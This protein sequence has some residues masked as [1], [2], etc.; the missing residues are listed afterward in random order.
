[1]RTTSFVL[2]LAVAASLGATA[3]G[4]NGRRPAAR[5]ILSVVLE[6][7]RCGARLLAMLLVT[8]LGLPPV[9]AD[10]PIPGYLMIADRNN[11][12]VLIVSPTKRI[13]W[14]DG[15][16]RGPDDAFFT[17]GYQSIITNEEFNDTLTEVSLATR[18]RIWRYGHDTVP[19]SSPGYLNTPDDAYRLRNGVTTVADVRNCRIV[20]ITHSKRVLRILG[21]V[22]GHDPP[23]ALASPNGDTPLPDGGLLVSEIGPPGWIDRLDAQGRL[24]WTVQSPVSYPS[25]A[26]LLPSGRILVAG[27]TDPGKIVE[28]TRAGRVTWSFGDLAGPNRLNKPSLAV[29]LPN[30]LIAATD[31]WNHRVIVI[32]PRTKRIVWQ[33]GHTGVPGTAPGYLDKPDGLDLLPAPAA[34]APRTVSSP[35]V[36][37]RRIGSLPSPITR[38][39][40]TALPGGR[41]ALLG[42]LVSGSS[43]PEVLTGTPEALKRAGTLPVAVHD[44]AAAYHGGRVWL[45]GGGQAASS[46]AVVTVNPA[47]GASRAVHPLDEAL[48]DLGAVAVGNRVYLVGGYTGARFASAVLRVGRGNRTVTVARLPDGIRYAGVAALGG[49]IYVAG[50]ITPAGPSSAIYRVDLRTGSV[51]QIGTLPRPLAHAPLV[52]SR[53]ALYLIGGDGSKLILHIDP[54]SGAVAQHWSTVADAFGSRRSDARS[55][56]GGGRRRRLKRRIRVRAVSAILTSAWPKRPALTRGKSKLSSPRRRRAWCCRW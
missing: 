31:D 15:A 23:R 36:V 26:H 1:M 20:E 16:L 7:R 22:C 3:C 48:S 4:S 50:G 33:Y 8:P 11:N 37:V 12:R 51:R 40:A 29:R 41:L 53:G 42:G 17:P 47:T 27:F 35:A 18:A 52:S 25:D 5:L 28:L 45:Y 21:G 46:P 34:S 6:R 39:A 14:R 49:N 44:A 54:S 30:G 32:D 56:G 9:P 38:A 13:V 55:A 24:V 2:V 43:S 19:G 10:S